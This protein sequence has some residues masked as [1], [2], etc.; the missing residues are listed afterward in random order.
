MKLG[1]MNPIQEIWWPMSFLRWDV[2]SSQEQTLFLPVNFSFS[3]EYWEIGNYWRESNK[4][5]WRQLRAWSISLMRKG[6]KSWNCLVQRAENVKLHPFLPI[7]LLAYIVVHM[8]HF[9]W[10]FLFHMYF[11]TQINFYV[12][13][14]VCL[15][16]CTVFQDKSP[17]ERE[18]AEHLYSN[19]G[20]WQISY[21][22]G[23]FPPILDS[24]FHFSS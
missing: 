18:C 4:G 1:E 22:T 19:Q 24:L 11:R 14:F 17:W 23:I 10:V 13:V 9:Y 2:S 8:P 16:G 12:C 6:W 5:P 7:K 20:N 3:N 21:T 15:S